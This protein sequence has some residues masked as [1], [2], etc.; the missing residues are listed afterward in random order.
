MT[1]FKVAFIG[2]PSSGKS[3]IINSLIGKRLLESGVCRTTTEYNLLDD[4]IED[5]NENKF[6][7]IDLPGICDSEERDSNFNELTY[8]YIKDANLIIW[9]SDVNKAF[10]TTH[11]VNEYNRI[12]EYINDLNNDNGK[13]YYL[14]ICLSKCDK[15]INNKKKVKNKKNKKINEEISDSEEDTDIND[16]IN[17]VNEKFP[18]ENIIYFNAFGRSYYNKKSS[19]SLK[20]F[21]EKN[22]IPS[23]YNILFNI[24]KYIKD[25][26]TNQDIEYWNKLQIKYQSFLNK[27]LTIIKLL[28]IWNNITEKDQD[29][30][31]NNICTEE[32][33][34]N[35]KIFQFLRM[36]NAL[37]ILN[38]KILYNKLIEY[39]IF[40][41]NHSEFKSI[42]YNYV[43]NLDD[44]NIYIYIMN[45][46]NNLNNL[47]KEI[48][49]NKLLFDYTYHCSDSYRINIISKI[50][51][52]YINIKYKYDF[53]NNFNQ[54]IIN[55]DI[56]HFQRF[57]NVIKASI[58]N[59]QE[60][61]F[62]YV[63][64]ES[65]EDIYVNN[66]ILLDNIY[67][68]DNYI[69]LNK[70]EILHD[71]IINNKNTHINCS[72]YK[73]LTSV[74]YIP[75]S[76]LKNNK[77]WITKNNLIWKKI[78]SNIK[79]SYNVTYNYIND[80]TPINKIELL[81][82]LEENKEEED[83]EEEEEEEDKKK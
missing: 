68:D 31:I 4:I 37:T 29:K 49:Y 83:D 60:Y 59:Q 24:T 82:N 44:T 19:P 53:D 10:I 7:V 40:M 52:I 64:N 11:E 81:Y 67:L 54:S 39:Y 12:K 2:L 34:P 78:Y 17:K 9:T 80:F 21:V 66:L 71:I 26:K 28:E 3:S 41:L 45:C 56:N 8:K 57:C 43:D 70:I 5:D 69:L 79:V 16:L 51:S 48:I 25:Y 6:K 35:F 58:I 47:N 50:D 36:L 62:K 13:L 32:F 27:S 46:F 63:I 38:D 61:N 74:N 72:Y 76:R 18:D 33:T 23:K 73:L 77:E 65:I 55:N 22:N 30:F 75:L 20:K 14:I 1:D 15:E 42:N